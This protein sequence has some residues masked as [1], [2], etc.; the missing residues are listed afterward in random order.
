MAFEEMRF[1]NH[2]IEKKL[3]FEVESLMTGGR[4]GFGQRRSSGN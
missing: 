3:I 2:E 1:I 4:V